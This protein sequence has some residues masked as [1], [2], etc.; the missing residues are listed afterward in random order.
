MMEAIFT[1]LALHSWW[2]ARREQR[3][4]WSAACWGAAALMMLAAGAVLGICLLA[5]AGFG[6]GPVSAA[7][8]FGRGFAA[9]ITRA[10]GTARAN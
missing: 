3:P 5:D 4:L 1:G 8:D 9:G 10:A 7:L 2:T 6:E